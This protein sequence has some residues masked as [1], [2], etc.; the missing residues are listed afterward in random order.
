[1][2]YEFM[3]YLVFLFTKGFYS[4]I[5]KLS[6]FDCKSFY[7]MGSILCIIFKLSLSLIKRKNMLTGNR[8]NFIYLVNVK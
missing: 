6:K 1:M 2:R 4:F 8:S 3:I 5:S 7:C